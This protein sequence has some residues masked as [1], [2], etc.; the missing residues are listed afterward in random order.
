MPINDVTE[1]ASYLP[2]EKAYELQTCYTY[3]ARR[4]VSRTTSAMT[5]EV[6]G[7][8]PRCHVVRLTG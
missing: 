5:S 3:G 4:P 7:Q 1:S 2:N 8:G 6:K